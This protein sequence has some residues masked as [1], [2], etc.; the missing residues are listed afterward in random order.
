MKKNT[1]KT[2]SFIKIDNFKKRI[3]YEQKIPLIRKFL[4]IKKQ[5]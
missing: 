5:N 4:F 3:D 2:N 1:K